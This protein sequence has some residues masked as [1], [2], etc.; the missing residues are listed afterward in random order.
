VKA[1]GHEQVYKGYLAN[2]IIQ[3]KK[4]LGISDK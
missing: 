4:E 1:A 3:K 2:L